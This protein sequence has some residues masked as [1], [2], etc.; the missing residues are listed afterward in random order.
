MNGKSV[1]H[2]LLKPSFF[3]LKT[4][5]IH[6]SFMASVISPPSRPFYQPE[7]DKPGHYK[8]V[9]MDEVD[10]NWHVIEEPEVVMEEEESSVFDDSEPGEEGAASDGDTAGKKFS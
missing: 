9:P 3:T 4:C 2:L 8:W 1:L 5:V 6:A 7:P 10:I